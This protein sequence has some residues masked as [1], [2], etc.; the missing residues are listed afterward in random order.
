M[1]AILRHSDVNVTRKNYIKPVQAGV[2]E[3]MNQLEIQLKTAAQE[4][5]RRQN[6]GIEGAVSVQ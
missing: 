6:S 5:L 2:M 3:A 4:E 1:Q